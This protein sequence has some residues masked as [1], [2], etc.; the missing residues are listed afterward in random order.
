MLATAV[1]LVE[2][3]GRELCACVSAL[4]LGL[5]IWLRWRNRVGSEAVRTGL[6]A[7]SGPLVAGLLLDR[8]DLQCGLAGGATACTAFAVLLG[9][10]AGLFIGLRQHQRPWSSALMAGGIAAL[11]A[12]LGCVRLGVVGVVGVIAG[13]GLGLVG[14]TSR[15]A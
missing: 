10:G 5:A 14:A 7:G 13:I 15:R 3:R 4:L 11:S 9:G 6:V 2:S 12:S 1:C 8:F